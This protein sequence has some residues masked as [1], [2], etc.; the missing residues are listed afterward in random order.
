MCGEYE[1]NFPVCLRRSTDDNARASEKRGVQ[2]FE[3]KKDFVVPLDLG[4]NLWAF[5]SIFKHEIKNKNAFNTPYLYLCVRFLCNLAQEQPQP[6]QPG[7]LLAQL[8]HAM[9]SLTW[10]RS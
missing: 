9:H 5:L 4:T 1:E 7:H 8:S 6:A 10:C 3:T 2:H